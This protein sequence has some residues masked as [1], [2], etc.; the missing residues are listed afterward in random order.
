MQKDRRTKEGLGIPNAIN[1]YII[2]DCGTDFFE[3]DFDGA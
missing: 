2:A 1:V 3:S